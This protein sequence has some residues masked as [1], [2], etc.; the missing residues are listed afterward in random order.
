MSNK[1]NIR[2]ANE[3]KANKRSGNIFL[4]Q[5]KAFN[6]TLSIILKLNLA[7]ALFFLFSILVSAVGVEINQVALNLSSGGNTTI[8]SGTLFIDATNN[9]VGVGTTSPGTNLDVAG[10]IRASGNLYT[11]SPGTYNQTILHQWGLSSNGSMY[12]EPA[13]GQILYLTDNW[14]YTG[15]LN[16]RFGSSYFQKGDVFIADN[17]GIGTINPVN[18]LTVVGDINATTNISTAKI[19]LKGD[20]IT[21][22]PTEGTAS[23]WTDSGTIVNLTTTTD[24][25]GIGTVT[26][27]AKLAVN[28]SSI[29]SIGS[30]NQ[31]AYDIG[32]G[33][34]AVGESLY[35]YGAIC[36][37]NSAGDCS[38]STGVTI[39]S[40]A[41]IGTPSVAIAESGN[42]Y[43]NAGNVGIGT[44]SPAAKLDVNGN[45]KVTGTLTVNGNDIYAGVPAGLIAIFTTACPTGWTRFSA[46]DNYFLRGSSTYGGTGGSNLIDITIDPPLTPADANSSSEKQVNSYS[47][48]GSYSWVSLGSHAHNVDIDPFTV[49]NVNI[50]PQFISVIFCQ[51][52]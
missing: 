39:T 15:Q 47:G 30:A 10:A 5:K 43:F 11:T 31:G 4:T 45:V 33:R 7:I 38:G 24:K 32:A 50:T 52:N 9:R 1:K 37:G 29:G 3:R 6:S 26:P 22:W 20:C 40:G 23:G 51:K 46:L 44:T 48:S 14:S 25:V 8:D 41:M 42:S 34:I 27:A 49:T 12:I 2:K 36:A 28:S 21:D 13:S 17:L 35:S 19:C 16:I 18:K